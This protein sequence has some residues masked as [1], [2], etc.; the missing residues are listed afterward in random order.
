MSAKTNYLENAVLSHFLRNVPVTSPSQTYLALFTADPGEAGNI[1]S[2]VSGGAYSRMPIDFGVAA[3]G[4]VANTERITFSGMLQTVITHIGIM[5]T[6]SGG[7]MLYYLEL[8][9]S[10]QVNPSN[11]VTFAAGIITVTEL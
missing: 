6:E 4:V 9:S 3:N 1:A 10:T 11:E 7:N 5:D 8:P 2:E